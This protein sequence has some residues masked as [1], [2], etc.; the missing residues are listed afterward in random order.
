[1]VDDSSPSEPIA[2]DRLGCIGPRRWCRPPTPTHVYAAGACAPRDPRFRANKSKNR[3]VILLD[4]F[5]LERI[6]KRCALTTFDEKN[7]SSEEVV[8]RLVPA[9]PLA[10]SESED[11]FLFFFYLYF[12]L[13]FFDP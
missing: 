13:R 3:V 4:L 6:S 1:M 2:K 5:L 11:Y 7:F 9:L 8:L 10:L 12:Y